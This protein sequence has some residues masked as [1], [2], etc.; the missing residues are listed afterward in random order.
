MQEKRFF[1][2]KPVA[3]SSCID[4]IFS[5]CC[6]ACHLAMHKLITKNVTL[7]KISVAHLAC[8]KNYLLLRKQRRTNW[9]GFKR[10]TEK[11]LTWVIFLLVKDWRAHYELFVEKVA[12]LPALLTLPLFPLCQ[13]SIP[14]VL[15][16]TSH[17]L[18]TFTFPEFLARIKAWL[19]WGVAVRSRC[20]KLAF[21]HLGGKW[22]FITEW[23]MVA[24]LRFEVTELL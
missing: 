23:R 11:I 24:H 2:L 9:T 4:T 16:P 15:F 21:S 12:K 3:K 14:F 22:L 18:A 19:Y 20:L 6:K 1:L 5:D 17:I 7:F 8:I 13:S 10:G